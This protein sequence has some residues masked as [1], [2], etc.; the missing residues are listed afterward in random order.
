MQCIKKSFAKYL[1]CCYHKNAEQFLQKSNYYRHIYIIASAMATHTENV[2]MA[3]IEKPQCNSNFSPTA[4]IIIIGDEILKG[5]TSDTNTYF[6]TKRLKQL[7]VKVRRVSVI[8]DQI[9]I[10]A[11]E[12]KA[13]SKSYRYV[14][15][16]GGIGPTH[17]DVTFEGE[18]EYC[19][20]G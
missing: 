9:E 13:F 15:T 19:W 1:T 10:I 20:N 4:G 7:G 8:S 3:V 11:D 5:Q 18:C 14:F 12:V 17:D 6:L 16:S 2:S